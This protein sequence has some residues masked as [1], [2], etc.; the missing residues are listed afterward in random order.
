MIDVNGTI[1]KSINDAF[2]MLRYQAKD[3][4][5]A[6]RSILEV[7]MVDYMLHWASGLLE[8]QE[9]LQKLVDLRHDLLMCNPALKLQHLDNSTAYVNV[10]TPQ[11]NADWKR[12]W[13]AQNVLNPSVDTIYLPCKEDTCTSG[14]TSLTKVNKITIN[15][16]IIP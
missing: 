15:N 13:D 3:D 2:G 6:F 1:Y 11:S 12:V 10:N 9:N 7:S 16:N 5:K 14:P 8:P 4:P